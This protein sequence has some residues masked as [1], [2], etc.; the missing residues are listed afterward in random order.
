MPEGD[1][2]ERSSLEKAL[3][4]KDDKI[5][6]QKYITDTEKLK[7]IFLISLAGYYVTEKEIVKKI[8]S[9]EVRQR[10]QILEKDESKA[11][12]N[13]NGAYYLYSQ[14]VPLISQ[15][16]TTSNLDEKN[17]FVAYNSKVT[18]LIFTLLD[19]YYFHGNTFGLRI[20][21][22]P[23][24]ISF[25]CS[26]QLISYK[27]REGFTLKQVSQTFISLFKT[28]ARPTEEKEKGFLGIFKK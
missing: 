15:L 3:E 16:T 18:T 26:F 21:Y 7:E 2:L 22:L 9:V 28:E 27:A 25:L 5:E 24:I 12:M 17:I 14:L 11:F 8:G 23:D 19:N 10:K 20:E 4:S 13:E 6:Y 1:V